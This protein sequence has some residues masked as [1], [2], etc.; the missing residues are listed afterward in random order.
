GSIVNVSGAMSFTGTGITPLAINPT[1]TIGTL[2]VGGDFSMTSTTGTVSLI[3]NA[4][5]IIN[6]GN[7]TFTY[8]NN[9]LPAIHATTSVNYISFL[10]ANSG[11]QW[12]TSALGAGTYRL[13]IGPAGTVSGL[14]PVSFVTSAASTGAVTLKVGFINHSN[15]GTQSATEVPLTGNNRA[16][17]IA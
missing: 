1:G 4:G 14:R 9:T 15:T 10:G 7:H 11:F 6:M 12:N 8:N 17:Y 3:T 13:P 2:N 16:A 5:G